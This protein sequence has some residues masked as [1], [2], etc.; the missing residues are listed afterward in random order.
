MI[1]LFN[2]LIFKQNNQIKIIT[3]KTTTKKYIMKK[4]KT[5]KN[6]FWGIFVVVH[7]KY[8]KH[9]CCFDVWIF[10]VKKYYQKATNYIIYQALQNGF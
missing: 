5:K 4:K 10:P 1:N 6:Q 3:N 7:C 9:G 8:I 2:N